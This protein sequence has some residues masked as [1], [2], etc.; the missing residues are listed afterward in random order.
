MS[1]TALGLSLADISLFAKTLRRELAQSPDF[2]T[3]VE[4]LNVLAKAAGFR[5]Y[6][7]LKASQAAEVRLSAAQER[8]VVDEAVDHRKIEQILRCFSPDGILLRW[9][10][11]TSH[12]KLALW[13]CWAALP[14]RR[15]LS[16]R[17]V[18]EILRRLNDFGDHVLMRRE[19]IDWGMMTRSQDCRV[20]RRVEGKPPAEAASLIARLQQR[21]RAS[22]TPRP[23]GRDSFRPDRTPVPPVASPTSP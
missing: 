21:K 13:W 7:H 2:P 6:Q 5:N 10:K 12:Q 17:E 8:P 20:Y 22:V 19:M 15:D 9:P 3:H 11:K 4:M 16:E 1:K 23:S 14:A 18:N